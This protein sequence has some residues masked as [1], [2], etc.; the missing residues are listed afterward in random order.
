MSEP[1]SERTLVVGRMDFEPIFV[2]FLNYFEEQIW[3]KT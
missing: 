3:V 2:C 1:A